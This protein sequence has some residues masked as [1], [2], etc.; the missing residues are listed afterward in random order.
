M[1]FHE[2]QFETDAESFSFLSRKTKKVL[3]LKKKKLSRTVKIHPK[4]GISRLN[5]PKG[6][7][8]FVLYLRPLETLTVNPQLFLQ[9]GA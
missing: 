6:F 1:R 8:L 3:F 2:I 4:D 7:A 5:F 9:I